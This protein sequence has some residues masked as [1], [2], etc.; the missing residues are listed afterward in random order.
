[1]S[2]SYLF[3]LI[4]FF[5]LIIFISPPILSHQG[6]HRRRPEAFAHRLV[7]ELRLGHRRPRQPAG[8]L[9]LPKLCR[10]RRPEMLRQSPHEPTAPAQTTPRLAVA[11]I[12]HRQRICRT[13]P[14]PQKNTMAPLELLPVVIASARACHG[15]RPRT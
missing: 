4:F 2:A 15:R 6:R 5:F 7:E 11:P 1:M 13:P 14:Q 10:R 3:P 12:V 8:H 9:I